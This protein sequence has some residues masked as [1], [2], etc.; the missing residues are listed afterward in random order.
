[1]FNKP[2][3]Y[4]KLPPKDR[5]KLHNKQR[6]RILAYMEKNGLNPHKLSLMAERDG[7]YFGVFLSDENRV[8]TRDVAKLLVNATKKSPNKLK[9][10]DF[11]Y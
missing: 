5:I 1:M 11:G 10:S 9:I 2:K 8:I 7:S 3:T 6:K 4:V